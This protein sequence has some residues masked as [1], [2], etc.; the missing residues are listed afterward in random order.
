LAVYQQEV[1]MLHSAVPLQALLNTLGA[2]EQHQK[3]A[4]KKTTTKAPGALFNVS[5][6]QAKRRCPASCLRI[7]SLPCD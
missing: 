5:F 7:A 3:R 4:N 6:R 1:L 2:Q